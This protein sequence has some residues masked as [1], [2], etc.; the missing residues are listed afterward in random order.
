[1]SKSVSIFAAPP[2]EQIKAIQESRLKD[3]VSD[4]QILKRLSEA[5]VNLLKND[6]LKECSP[7][8][9]LGALYK[10]A[11]LGCRLEPE[12]GECYIIPR[13][14]NGQATATFQL[15]YKF[16]RA[17]ALEC[18]A[19]SYIQAHTVD[20][21][22][23]FS[24]QYGTGKH[25]THTP[26]TEPSGQYSHF[27]AFAEL[28][29]GQ[30][31]FEVIN[32]VEAER[33]RKFSETQY[34]WLPGEHGRKQ[35]VFSKAPKDIWLWHYGAMALRVPMK[36][37]C[38]ALPMN[39]NFEEANLSDGSVTYLQEDGQLVTIS[40]KETESSADFNK[41]KGAEITDE[42]F[43]ALQ[44][45][46]AYLEGMDLEQAKAY[47]QDKQ[48]TEHGGIVQFAVLFAGAFC[49]KASSMDELSPCWTLLKKWQTNQEVKELFT[50]ARK[51]FENQA[52]P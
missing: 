2:E 12:F 27:Y 5:A 9:I 30:N 44:D 34:D 10:A 16:W 23:E 36:K 20:T 45:D 38:A 8:S 43:D 33:S 15:G 21:N 3:L 47:W 22:D 31:V 50:G 37:L 32:S 42:M 4:P 17:Q 28:P 1:M 40:P 18:G 41:D 19:A 49:A 29:N 13:K 35:K 25:L 51:R 7:E 11:S 39:K 14:I 52:K 24:F 6:K 48:Q 46:Q 26:T